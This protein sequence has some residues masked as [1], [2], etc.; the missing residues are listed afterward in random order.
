MNHEKLWAALKEVGFDCQHLI[1][2]MCNLHCG[3]KAT[4]RTEYGDTEW[5]PMGKGVRQG[6]I[7]SSYLFKLYTEHIIRK[8]GLVS[9]GGGVKTGGRN[10][11]DLRY[12]G[13]T[14]LV[15]ES[16]N[17][18]KPLLTKVRE[19]H[20]KGGLHSNI[21]TTKITSTEEVH[22]S[23]VDKEDTEIVKGFVYLGSVIKVN[24]DCSQ[25]TK[26]RLRLGRAATKELGKIIKC[27]EVSLETKAKT[28]HSLGF[29]TTMYGC[30]SWTAKK[31]D[32]GKMDFHLK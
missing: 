29:L 14:I 2:L 3:Q 4:V 31:T 25:E 5:F 23:N 10:I 30:E 16:S 24:G 27:K 22:H 7:L 28:L 17:D 6:Y 8:T 20:A 9:D 18:L 1:V 26:T 19:E 21:K 15:A 32:G 13:D 11:H 12:A